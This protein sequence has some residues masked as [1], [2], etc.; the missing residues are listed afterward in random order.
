MITLFHTTDV[1]FTTNG[2]GSLKDAISCIVVEELNGEFG[3]E[4]EYPIRGQHF[5]DLSLR[6]IIL[7]KPNPYATPQPFR[8]WAIT[9]PIN[10]IVTVSAQHISYDMSGYPVAPFTATAVTNALTNI[11]NNSVVACPFTFVTYKTNVATLKTS[12]P[13]SMRTLIG[14]N[15]I[16]TYGG[17]YEFDKF[18]VTLH[19]DRGQNR[20]VSIRYG[21]NLTDLKQEENCSAVYTGVY[22]YWYSEA[23]GIFQ[24]PEKVLNAS[25]TYDF[26]RIYALDLSSVWSDKP[27]EAQLRTEATNYMTKYKIGVPK[28]SIDLSF[29]QLGQSDEYKNFATVETVKLADHVVVEF[30]EMNVSATAQCIK[31]IYNVLTNKYDNLELGDVKSNIA[32]TITDGFK[33][34]NQKIQDNKLKFSAE[35]DTIKIGLAD[36]NDAMIGKADISY[37]ESN[38]A[39]ITNGYLDVAQIGDASIKNAH[40]DRATANKLQVVTADIVDANIT[41][42]KI[43]RI[44]ANK[45]KVVTAD[46]VD[47]NITNAKIDRASVDKLQVVSADIVDANITNAKIDRVTANKLKVVTADIV[48]G[49]ITNAKIDRA[50]VDKLVVVSADIEDSAIKTA[51]IEN[52]SITNAKIDRVSVNKLQVADADIDRASVNKIQ[53]R[54]ADIDRATVNKIQIRDADIDRAS[55]NKLIVKTADIDAL[56]VTSAKIKSIDGDIATITN[57]KAESITTGALTIQANNLIHE[58]DF[59]DISTWT[60][61][62][63]TLPD[64]TWVIDDVLKYD[65]SST[66]KISRTGFVSDVYCNA[67]SEWQSTSPGQKFVATIYSYSENI[68]LI[69]SV[70][71]SFYLEF[72]D[73]LKTTRLGYSTVTSIKPTINSIWQKYSTVGTVPANAVYVRLRFYTLRNGTI[74]IARPMVQKGTISSEWTL[75]VDELIS[76]GAITGDLIAGNTIDGDKLTELSIGDRELKV[77]AVK[78]DKIDAGAVKAINIDTDAITSDKIFAKAVTAD[79]INALGLKITN[80]GIDTFVVQSDGQVSMAGDVNSLNYNS[81]TKAGWKISSDGN[82]DFYNATVRGDLLLP[83]SGMTSMYDS[84]SIYGRNLALNSLVNLSDTTYLMYNGIISKDFVTGNVYTCVIEGTKEVTQNIG[85]WQNSGDTGKGNFT[86]IGT[87]NRW[88]LTFTS[89][90]TN[91]GDERKFSLYNPPASSCAWTLGFVYLYEGSDVINDWSPAPEDNPNPVRIWAGTDFI[92]REVAP[93]RV[94]QDGSIVANQGTFN[95]TLSGRVDIG[96]IHIIDTNATNASLKINSNNDT[97][98]IIQLEEETSYINTEFIIGNTVDKHF[99]VNPVSDIASFETV[100]VSIN[101]TTGNNNV[102]FPNQDTGDLLEFVDNSFSVVQDPTSKALKFQTN[103]PSTDEDFRFERA[104][105]PGDVSV[106]VDGDLAITNRIEISNLSI[107]KKSDG[108][109]FIFN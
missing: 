80:D 64:T 45:L 95:G 36:I 35:V 109:D 32:T 4:M 33:K 49:N 28:V 93:Y 24:L 84:T 104:G 11:K 72:Y 29:V 81:I 78:T 99:Y 68:S 70:A 12:V 73:S 52:G 62:P 22:P 89:S 98:T 58:S 86:Q 25:G 54:D 97:D 50:S 20:G 63:V 6:R 15:V 8:I 75:H 42:A 2:L 17:E 1:N 87:T 41:N 79:K 53:I 10:G 106:L 16:D 40:I 85:L 108:I 102:V 5:L 48:D 94:Y 47:A 7:V 74:N 19:A 67:Y 96:N 88:Y 91:I 51:K 23:S 71:P 59:R 77:G 61:D 21:K 38:Y 69:D 103:I 55:V 30:V 39:H 107:Q 82:A 66:L 100:A 31:A 65:I 13:T 18:N 9:K 14:V 26:T 76:D 3:L 46:I 83:N 43:D 60:I 27:T 44:T 105:V 57:V 92:N 101:P 34:T 37:L 90:A 56:A